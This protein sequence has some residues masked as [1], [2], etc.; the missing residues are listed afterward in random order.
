MLV[1][2]TDAAIRKALKIA[3]RQKL[4]DGGGMYL[5]VDPPRNPGWR[6]KY[7][8]A[9]R[10]KLLSLGVY[11]RVPLQRAR[12]KREDARRLIGEGLDPSVERKAERAAKS[13]TFRLVAEDWLARQA[14]VL[15][16]ETVSILQG[17]L[18]S[19]LFPAF[20]GRPI[21]EIKAADLL[22]V[23]RRLEDK[24]THETAHRVR[25]LYGRVARFAIATD[26][27]ERD[28]SADLK[29]ALTPVATEHFPSIKDPRRIGELLRA[30]DSYDG[31]PSVEYALKIAPYV[32]MRPIELR[33]AAWREF[34]LAAA[35][36]RIP[37]ER[38]KM[39]RE[40]IVPLASQVVKLL[41]QLQALT[42]DG[43][44]LFPGLRAPS[45]PISNGTLNAALRRLDFG[46]DEMTSHGFRSMASTLLNE[47]HTPGGERRFSSDWIERQ[48]AHAEKDG[49]RA[50]YN[51][52]EYLPQ[53]RKMMQ[54]WADYL[55]QLRS[56]P[57][58]QTMG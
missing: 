4:T 29:G 52:A 49:V 46:Q 30:I 8:I 13:D 5:L 18:T 20:G 19:T 42:G 34:D 55:D 6:L 35:E 25:A 38:M 53:R 22:A 21:S 36:W 41:R 33:G 2:L 1:P 11:P 9:G 12:E 28:I 27:A 15:A 26:R 14:K 39:K 44:L 51:A 31:Q 7:R 17:R 24:G 40:H 3:A 23:L 50:A 57:L 54:W 32:F 10:E 48:L 43:E 47:Q 37:A 45:R 56:R 58:P 16:P